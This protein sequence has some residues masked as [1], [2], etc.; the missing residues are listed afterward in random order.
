MAIP[1]EPAQAGSNP[2][3][4][5]V[6]LVVVFTVFLDLVGFG[7]VMPLLPLY[8]QRMQASEVIIGLMFSSFSLAQFVATPLLGRLSDEYGR[9]RIILFSLAGNAISMIVFAIGVQKSLLWILF[10]SRLFAGATAGNLSACQ[11][12]IADVTDRK[13]RAA[14]M[15]RLGA[16]IGLGLIVGPLLGAVLG[17][18]PWAPPAAAAAMAVVD[19]VL[20]FFLMPETLGARR[21]LPPVKAREVASRGEGTSPAASIAETPPPA[22]ARALPSIR[23]VLSEQRMVG[24]LMLFFLTF[25]CMTNLQASLALLAKERLRWGES[26]MG[27]VFAL[28]GGCAFI[29][30]GGLIGRLAKSIGEGYLVIIGAL[31]NGGGMIAIGFAKS[32]PILVAGVVLLGLGVA[33][34]NPSLSSLASR[35]ARDEQQ[36]AVLGAAQSAG[37]LGR[38]IGPT[39]STYLYGKIDSS[40][41]FLSGAVVALLSALIGARLRA[42][43]AKESPMDVTGASDA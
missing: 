27:F 42:T 21:S 29:V 41:P 39:W 28:F 16:G 30:Q 6:L 10:V 33:I 25:V 5:R 34:T 2:L 4:R 19:V 20:T 11:A 14:A 9:R 26:E 13:E 43:I 31:L 22:P 37:T 7:I 18:I 38:I 1:S 3:Q 32:S 40:A 24:V 15:G 12:A 23:A 35:L 36:G 8:I 17:K